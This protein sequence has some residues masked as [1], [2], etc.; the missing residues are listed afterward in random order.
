MFSLAVDAARQSCTGLIDLTETNP[1][2]V[3][4]T[5]PPAIAAALADPA[6]LVYRPDPSGLAEARRA[7]ADHLGDG[8]SSERL[9][10]TAS[11]SEA[12]AMLFKLLCD[13]GD[14]VLVPRP[15]YPLFALLTGLESV[16]AIPYRLDV[17]GAWCLDRRSL[18]SSLSTRTRAI[19]VVSP[20]NPT[21]SLLH[22]DDREWLVTLAVQRHVA[23]IADEVFAPYPLRPR[24]PSR[25]LARESRTLT[26]TLG[27][28]SKSAGLP[29]VKLGWIVLNGPAP[30]VTE[31]RARLEIIADT[32]LSVST[33]VQ[34]AASRLIEAGRTVR[35]QILDR[36]RGNLAVLR[37][38]IAREPA[39]TL[40]EP[41]AGWS[42]VIRVP[43]IVAEDVLVLRLLREA[44]VLVHPG[45]FF[46]F[47]EEAFLVV[48]LLPPQAAFAEGIA[49][50][51]R[52]VADIRHG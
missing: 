47:D 17:H 52:T 7:V 18:E 9:V 35:A 26:F 20:N 27:G 14:E 30:R 50:I 39:L 1:T 32:Y 33:P 16:Q 3:D 48:S 21:G 38:A 25:S 37:T 44:D 29:Q 36:V 34:V 15:S 49:R 12:Y 13:P 8:V 40:V 4:F 22:D 6:A 10:L 11:T 5:Y 23:I 45:Y 24:E 42:A 28:L 19:L 51:V 43:A 2:R 46:D 41:E 31:A